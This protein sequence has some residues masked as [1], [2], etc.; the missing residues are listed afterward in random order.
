MTW[1][2]IKEMFVSLHMIQ[3]EK[4]VTKSVKL[5]RKGWGQLQVIIGR[6]TIK[7]YVNYG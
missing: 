4:N 5:P 2:I 1:S 3:N 7:E 6:Q